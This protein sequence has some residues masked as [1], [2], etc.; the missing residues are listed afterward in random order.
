MVFFLGKLWLEHIVCSARMF[1]SPSPLYIPD[2]LFMD[3][4]FSFACNSNASSTISTLGI[5]C[6]EKSRSSIL[7]VAVFIT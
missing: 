4:M 3:F 1:L 5:K 2:N 7:L 6:G